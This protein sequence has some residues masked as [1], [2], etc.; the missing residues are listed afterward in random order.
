MRRQF[1]LSFNISF[2]FNQTERGQAVGGPTLVL[3]ARPASCDSGTGE[4]QL[5]EISVGKQQKRC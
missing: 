2:P 4:V 1:T 5:R 3:S